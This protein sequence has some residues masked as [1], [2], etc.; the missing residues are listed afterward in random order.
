MGLVQ[1][2]ISDLEKRK[3]SIACGGKDGLL[4]LLGDLGFQY[5]RAGDAQHH[6]FHHPHLPMDFIH[7]ID[8]GHYPKKPMKISYVAKTI[9][10]L[11]KYQNELE[12]LYEN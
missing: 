3:R 7:S 11:R 9:R 2:A 4:S 10:M 5:R 1:E 12:E 6:V 8:C